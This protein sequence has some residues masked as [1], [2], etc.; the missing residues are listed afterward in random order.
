MIQRNNTQFVTED[1]KIFAEQVEDV[2]QMLQL[3]YP[4]GD[5]GLNDQTYGLEF[6]T[7]IQ[8]GDV[9]TLRKLLL[10]TDGDNPEIPSYKYRNDVTRIFES[11]SQE[12]KDTREQTLKDPNLTMGLSLIHI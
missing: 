3:M 4:T 2:L 8:R 10:T 12:F 7:G 6:G 11:M 1:N 9:Q 5:S